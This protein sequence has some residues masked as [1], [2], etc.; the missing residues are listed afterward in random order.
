MTTKRY[1]SDK[2][3][4][5][6]SQLLEDPGLLTR[7]AAKNLI[8]I[9]ICGNSTKI[10]FQNVF[11]ERV[12]VS[13]LV[14][15]WDTVIRPEIYDI[16]VCNNLFQYTPI[17]HFVKLRFI[18]FT[19]AGLD[20]VPLQYINEHN[21]RYKSAKGLY[22]IPIAEYTVGRILE[23]YKKFFITNTLMA[24]REWKKLRELQELNE[25]TVV[26]YGYG[27]IGCEIAQRLKGFNTE[28]VGISRTMRSD[29]TL[30]F[31][32]DPEHAEAYLKN[33]DLLIITIPLT[34][35][36]YHMVDLK[37][38]S[39]LKPTCLLVNV[40]RGGVVNTED[41]I[42]ALNKGKI[43]GAI[44][45]VF[46]KEPLPLDN[47]LWRLPNVFLSPHN[48]FES[49]CNLKRLKALIVKNVQLELLREGYK[50]E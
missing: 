47:P 19:S 5:E 16:L 50:Q 38:L 37:F 46:E 20:R 28:I 14:N 45:D 15:E 9:L 18:Q 2:T 22:A 7:N 31:W 43:A 26:I 25:K 17:D 8:K 40:S 29:D 33:A 36:T 13:Y 42:E 10:D 6:L 23:W 32:T 21:I 11:P 39:L 34:N 4:V 49:E 3:R 24:N 12:K 27:S 30:S 44:L 1:D 41:L 48:S 35:E